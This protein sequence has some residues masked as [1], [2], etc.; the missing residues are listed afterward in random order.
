[1][2]TKKILLLAMVFLLAGCSGKPMELP[3]G[4]EIRSVE[5]YG[6]SEP[7]GIAVQETK[8][9]IQMILDQFAQAK[10]TREESVNDAPQDA[11][12]ILRV[13]LVHE[14]GGA[15]TLFVY[16]KNGKYFAEQPYAGIWE[17][18]GEVY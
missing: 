9:E 12:G 8:E 13:D 10:A 11:E 2:R 1:M 3:K 5:V 6:V 15:S 17:I 16:Q 7:S 18:S 14:E 4:E